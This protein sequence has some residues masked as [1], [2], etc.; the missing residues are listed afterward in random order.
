MALLH[1]AISCAALSGTKIEAVTVDHGLRSEAA[2]EAEGVAHY[3]EQE[4][5]PHTILK[6][7]GLAAKGNIAAAAREARFRLMADWAKERDI[8]GI[9][10]GHTANDI[11]ETFLMRLARKAG[12]DG[13]AAMDVRFNRHGIVW[14]RPFWQQTRDRL[15]DYLR[16]HGVAWVEDPTNVDENHDR[17]RMRRILSLLEDEG[18]GVEEI[19]STAH[20]LKMART[21]LEDTTAEAAKL[22]VTS[23]C[24]DL[25][26]TRNADPPVA[27]EIERRL[28]NAALRY[29]SG[30]G[31]PPREKAYNG[32]LR[33]LIEQDTYTVAGCLVTIERPEGIVNQKVRVARE[34]NAVKDLVGPSDVTWDNRWAIDGPHAPN[35]TIRALGESLKDVPD[36]RDV[37]LPR[38]SLMASPAVFDGETL[39]SAPIAGLQNGFSARIVADFQSFL[40]SR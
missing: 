11:A 26:V 14:A 40:L 23:D 10:L 25:I 35:L 39:I 33:A 27:G 7:D 22:L 36:W 29:V 16:R 24:C 21:A 5:I 3:C 15:R 2:D 31:Y 12:V 8:G 38:A 30:T 6:W 13:L 9:L 19:K 1:A 28:L 18:I 34:F 32:M 37:G 17:P 4:G 20:R